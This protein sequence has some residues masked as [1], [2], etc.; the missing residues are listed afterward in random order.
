MQKS[1]KKKDR[2]SSASSRA[3]GGYRDQ[4]SLQMQQPTIQ[5]KQKTRRKRKVG[6][7]VMQNPDAAARGFGPGQ[8][9]PGGNYGNYQQSFNAL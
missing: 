5:E 7:E 8:G 9:H 2:E 4:A 3:G 1:N 6:Q